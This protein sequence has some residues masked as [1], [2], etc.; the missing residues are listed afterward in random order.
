MPGIECV[1]FGLPDFPTGVFYP[2]GAAYW[3]YDDYVYYS[4][5]V[6]YAK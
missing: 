4:C 5:T 6:L 3:L 2:G 1:G